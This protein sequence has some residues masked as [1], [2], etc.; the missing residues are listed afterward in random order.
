MNI[1]TT[2]KTNLH[3][4]KYAIHLTDN[5]KQYIDVLMDK[6]PEVFAKIQQ[7]MDEIM[8]DGVVDLYDIPKIIL[9][10]SQMYQANVLKE[11][12]QHIRLLS[13][14]KFTI[15]CLLDSGLLPIPQVEVAII[16]RIVDTTIDLLST[17]MDT[18][19]KGT[20]KVRTWLHW[21]CCSNFD[22]DDTNDAF[23]CTRYGGCGQCGQCG[24][25]VGCTRYGGCVDCSQCTR[26]GGCIR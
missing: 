5:E 23:N 15:D 4:E 10:I 21:V 19:T 22:D 3:L 26:N 13:L 16:K 6:N 24:E 11:F 14:V 17:N 2:L 18:I 1:I 7:T 25:C 9:L 12:I 8:A 20:K